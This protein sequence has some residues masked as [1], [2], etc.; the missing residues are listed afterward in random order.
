MT[1]TCDL[2]IRLYRVSCY[3]SQVVRACSFDIKFLKLSWSRF[4]DVDNL[5]VS[6]TVS[7]D[8]FEIQFCMSRADYAYIYLQIRADQTASTVI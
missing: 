1:F 3:G 8:Y 5:E 2:G 6:G 7:W 4:T